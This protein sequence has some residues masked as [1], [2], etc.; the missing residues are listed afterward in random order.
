M[1]TSTKRISDHRLAVVIAAIGTILVTAYAGLAALQILV[2][3]PLAAVSLAWIGYWTF[4]AAT[5]YTGPRPVAESGPGLWV[6]TVL[7]ALAL[8]TMGLVVGAVGA[9]TRRRWSPVTLW[10]GA[11]M[12][13]AGTI[14]QPGIGVATLVSGGMLVAAGVG[15]RRAR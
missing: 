2:L 5:A 10:A 6:A 14:L 11:S 4:Y 8:S 12:M 7:P 13:L 15:R 3:N 9:L 1:T